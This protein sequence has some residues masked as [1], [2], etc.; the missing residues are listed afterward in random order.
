[1]GM[2]TKPVDI[3]SMFREIKTL[4]EK[5]N[6]PK[7]MLLVPDRLEICVQRVSCENFDLSYKEFF[8]YL[9]NQMLDLVIPNSINVLVQIGVPRELITRIGNGVSL[10]LSGNFSE[11]LAM[12]LPE[13]LIQKRFEDDELSTLFNFV[14]KARKS[15]VEFSDFEYE[16]NS[17]V[18]KRFYDI[19]NDLFRVVQQYPSAL[20]ELE[21]IVNKYT[22]PSEN[23]EFEDK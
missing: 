17:E 15:F 20:V 14:Q 13:L 7:G 6:M 16:W 18:K 9:P 3:E 23:Q 12:I 21:A 22:Q 1:M 2:P 5:Y 8:N 4:R 19:L 11:I 10:E